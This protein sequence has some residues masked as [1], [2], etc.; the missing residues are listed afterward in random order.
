MVSWEAA[1]AYCEGRGGVRSADSTPMTWVGAPDEEWRSV[2]G[3]PASRT[4]GGDV[5]TGEPNGRAI[6][7]RGFRCT[8]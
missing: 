2:D 1:S 3:L 4:S 5:K 7:E 8:R 6:A